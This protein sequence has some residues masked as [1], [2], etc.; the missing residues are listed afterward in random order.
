[1]IRDLS[2]GGLCLSSERRFERGTILL[3]ELPAGLCSMRSLLVHVKY[4]L[5][6]NKDG[7]VLGCAFL[8]KLSDNE[9]QELVVDNPD[10]L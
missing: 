1:V 4:V 2:R 6:A 8:E 5:P 3:V 7:W 9:V 10:S